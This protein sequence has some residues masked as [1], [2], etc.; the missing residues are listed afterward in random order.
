MKVNEATLISS[1]IALSSLASLKMMTLA[2]DKQDQAKDLAEQEKINREHKDKLKKQ[3]ERVLFTGNSEV[4][5]T[6]YEIQSKPT[7]SEAPTYTAALMSTAVVV[8]IILLVRWDSYWINVLITLS[9]VIFSTYKLNSAR[10]FQ[11]R[12]RKRASRDFRDQAEVNREVLLRGLAPSLPSTASSLPAAPSSSS[13][14]SPPPPPPPPSPPPP[15]PRL[16]PFSPLNPAEHKT[17]P[18]PFPVPPPVA[19][20]V[21]QFELPR[22]VSYP[23][24]EKVTWLNIAIRRLW[25][26]LKVFIANQ[27]QLT[28]GPT[29]ETSKPEWLTKFGFQETG[30]KTSKTRKKISFDFGTSPL[31]IVGIKTYDQTGEDS[32]VIDIGLS[33]HTIDSNI[34][35]EMGVAA[36]PSFKI[37]LKDLGFSARLRVELLHLSVDPASSFI[38]SIAL[39]FTQ[40]PDIAF[41]LS[42]PNV[43]GLSFTDFP[44]VHDF[45][46]SFL[47]DTLVS[48]MVLPHRVIIPCT[49][50]TDEERSILSTKPPIGVVVVRVIGAR[51]LSH[52]RW[53]NNL[54]SL[55]HRSLPPMLCKHYIQVK[56]GNQVRSTRPVRF[57]TS[58]AYDETFTLIIYSKD[59]HLLEFETVATRLMSTQDLNIGR[60]SMALQSLTANSLRKMVRNF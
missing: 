17:P 48:L 41:E 1:V 37:Q 52:A 36:I 44:L 11:D 42:T 34:V 26:Y 32:V 12:E 39:S 21:S 20:A 29:L 18:L 24:V 16:S 5:C 58:P 31:K 10:R 43:G 40:R 35:F 8:I 2:M 30:D 53:Y 4:D 60:A 49:D 47:K 23:D 45:L 28:L 27:I 13:S 3:Q 25:P 50:L 33:L 9:V 57:T 59:S 38:G 15:P 22:W 14:S 6:Y 51:N 56:L 19:A 7:S 46:T 55:L 54:T